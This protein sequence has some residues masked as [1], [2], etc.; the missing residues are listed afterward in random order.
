MRGEPPSTF[1]MSN[2]V[3]MLPQ[4]TVSQAGITPCKGKVQ[5]PGN[6]TFMQAKPILSPSAQK[7]LDM[8][9]DSEAASVS[10]VESNRLLCKIAGTVACID[11]SILRPALTDQQQIPVCQPRM[12]R[13]I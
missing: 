8:P 11:S 2:S 10:R 12:A 13:S 1:Y 5:I 3:G 4:I 6:R 9:G 7:G